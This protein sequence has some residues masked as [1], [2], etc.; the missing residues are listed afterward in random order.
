MKRETLA[1]TVFRQLQGEILGGELA[2]GE[3]LLPERALAEKLGVNRGAIREAL[4]KLDN[5]KLIATRQGGKTR[6][7]DYRETAGLDLISVLIFDSQRVPNREVM[8]S[9]VELRV[10]FQPDMARLAVLR[11]DEGLLPKLRTILTEIREPDTTV[12]ENH[13][14]TEDFWQELGRQCGN[15]SYRLILNTL[16]SIRESDGFVEQRRFREAY[17]DFSHFER[18]ADAVESGDANAAYLAAKERSDVI[19]ALVSKLMIQPQG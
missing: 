17:R 10:A 9:L 11:G 19:G 3:L 4:K 6:V 5:A 1:E 18:I 12:E 7:L 14:L 15:I 8:Q 13:S 2:P 16:R